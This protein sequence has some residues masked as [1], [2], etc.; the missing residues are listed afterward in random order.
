MAENIATVLRH[1]NYFIDIAND[2]ETGLHKAS[3][4]NYNLVILD[5][6]LPLLDGIEVCKKIREIGTKTPII[7]LTAR[8]DL[9][10]R[11]EGLD[12]GADDYLTKPFMMEELTA[13][14][15]ALLRRESKVKNTKI[16]LPGKITMDLAAKQISK[17]GIEVNLSPVEI[18][19]LEYLVTNRGHV[20]S[21][22]E[23]YEN[24][25][26]LYNEDVIFSDSLKV[27]IARI[28]KKLDPD[29]I[30][31]VKGFGYVIE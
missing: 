3:T 6:N 8:I 2:G 5:L 20:K 14:I 15:R 29:I 26:G 1:E 30:K 13:R 21:P 16:E 12:S 18:R 25:W 11:V 23:I 27:H 24:A 31:T 22:T 7:M 9:D 10:S 17:K 19:I 28:R 4:K